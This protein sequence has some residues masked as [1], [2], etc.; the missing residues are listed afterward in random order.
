MLT[1]SFIAPRAL[2]RLDFDKENDCLNQNLTK[3]MTKPNKTKVTHSYETHF[4]TVKVQKQ[5]FQ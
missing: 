4:P 1:K 2:T 3:N 5:L